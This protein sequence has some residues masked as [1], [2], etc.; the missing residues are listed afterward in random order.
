MKIASIMEN[1]TLVAPRIKGY[2]GTSSYVHNVRKGLIVNN[3]KY[4]TKYVTKREISLFGKPYFGI[5][6]QAISA[7]FVYTNSN[8]VHSLSPE[9]VTRNTNVVTIHDIIPFTRPD[10]YQKSSYDRIA[11]KVAF[12]KSL[13]VNHILVSTNYGKK[14]FLEHTNIQKERVHVVYH[15]IDNESFFYDPVDNLFDKDKVNVVMMSDFNP[16]KRI[17]RIVEAV[18]NDREITFYHIG[19]TQNWSNNYRR[20]LGMAKGA[21]N[22]HFM[23]PLETK[24]ARKY[25]S[26]AD[27]FIYLSEDEGFGYPIL[28]SF[29]C[30][31]NVL[32]NNIPVFDE[33]FREVA[34]FSES[35]DITRETI[36]ESLKNKRSMESLQKFASNFSADK[37]GKNLLK[38]YQDVS[39]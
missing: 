25:L 1:I 5:L 13:R 8:V 35:I 23:G 4:D 15:S 21:S 3:V 27:L 33:L 18:K 20:I 2:S 32:L 16:R 22:I 30:G 34:I 37:M 6:F 38:I 14:Q 31:T 17:D 39:R 10:L 28:E 29:S 19:P 7:K 24:V 36:L 12:E 9:V 26:S 11:Y